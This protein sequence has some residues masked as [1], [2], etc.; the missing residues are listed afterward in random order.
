MKKSLLLCLMCSVSY[1]AHSSEKTCSGDMISVNAFNNFIFTQEQ[2]FNDS[3]KEINLR[4][5]SKDDYIS[6]NTHAEFDGCGVLLKL[7]SNEVIKSQIK[8]NILIN[9]T[10]MAINKNDKIWGYKMTF[11]MSAVNQDGIEKNIM[12]QKMSG[13]FQTDINGKINKSE[14]T[15]YVLIGKDRM[16]AK[17]VTTFLIDDKDRVSESSRVSTMKNDSVNTIYSYD[18]KNRLIQTRSGSTIE[19][20]TYGDDNRELS[21]KKVQEFF[22]TETTVTTCKDW[23]KF[24]RCTDAE[25]DISV[26]IKGDK[27][28]KDAIYNHHAD[29][30]YDY[31]Y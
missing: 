17:A 24:G 18:S 19:E 28:K 8:E 21:S 14:D 31:V 1:N 13:K 10:D 12:L 5:K 26:L 20:F 4:I 11:K 23:N 6:N 29:I 22:T 3:L 27:G 16:S 25:Q 7:K 15:S 9:A 2:P 30:K